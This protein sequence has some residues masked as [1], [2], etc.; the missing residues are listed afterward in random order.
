MLSSFSCLVHMD[1]PYVCA[2]VHDQ[3]CASLELRFDYE[4]APA[5]HCKL[6]TSKKQKLFLLMTLHIKV[7]LT[8]RLMPQIKSTKAK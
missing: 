4:S 7:S 5:I 8:A 2:G 1:L 6:I 3:F